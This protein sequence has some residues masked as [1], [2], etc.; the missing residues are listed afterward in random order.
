MEVS[1]AS[2]KPSHRR[3]LSYFLTMLVAYIVV[4]LLVRMFESH[5]IFFANY[6]DRLEGDWHPRALKSF[7]CFGAPN[8]AAIASF[9]K[10]L[11][12][13]HPRF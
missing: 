2:K 5:L 10:R 9:D 12:P 4:L 11:A 3:L 1:N 7:A 13:G 8:G 6:P